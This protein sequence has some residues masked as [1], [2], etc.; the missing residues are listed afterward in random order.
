M[1]DDTRYLMA[2]AVRQAYREGE[3]DDETLE[4]IVRA[5]AGGTPVGRIQDGDYVIFYNIHGK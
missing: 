1:V 2:E 4:P 3:D 5:D